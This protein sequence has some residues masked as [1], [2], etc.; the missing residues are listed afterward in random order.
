MVPGRAC[1]F[2]ATFTHPMFFS[3]RTVE[4]LD[5]A[6]EHGLIDPDSLPPKFGG[7]RWGLPATTGWDI[8]P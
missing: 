8:A 4:A 2:L 3:G 7:A 5:L 6:I 1:A